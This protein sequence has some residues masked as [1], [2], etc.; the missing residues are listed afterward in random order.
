APLRAIQSFTQIILTDHGDKIGLPG[1]DYLQRT[2]KAAARLDRLIQDVLAVSRMARQK[3]MVQPVNVEK[4][5]LEIIQER[6][7]LRPPNAEIIIQGP[8]LPMLGHEASLNQCLSNLL[9]NAVKFVAPGVKPQVRIYSTRSLDQVRLW[10][11]DNGIGIA[12][13]AQRGL[14]RMFHRLH[15]EKEYEGTGI[16]LAIVL[17]AAERMGGQTGMESEPGRGSR[18]WVQL[19]AVD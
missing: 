5:I 10:I 2:A 18:F 6:A 8:L 4:Q 11:E 3:V 7:E 19:P 13:E 14:F 9:G 1:T 15:T 12:P 16:G 17:K